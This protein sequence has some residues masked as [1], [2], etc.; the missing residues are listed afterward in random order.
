MREH[1]GI[2]SLHQ[3]FQFEYITHHVYPQ[4]PRK[5]AQDQFDA[6]LHSADLP[7][8]S[9]L[10]PIVL[11]KPYSCKPSNSIRKH[12]APKLASTT[13]IH[14]AFTS[15]EED[16]CSLADS[17]CADSLQMHGFECSLMHRTNITSL[18]WTHC[19]TCCRGPGTGGTSL[20]SA[21]NHVDSLTSPTS[22]CCINS[23]LHAVLLRTSPQYWGARQAI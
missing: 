16:V 13:L 17:A 2:C 6:H 19:W 9:P 14:S 11:I 23:Q 3:L 7:W 1:V 20:S 8:D 15:R 22:L 12:M 21:M 5:P 18:A 4:P 10:A